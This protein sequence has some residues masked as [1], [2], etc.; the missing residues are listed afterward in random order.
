MNM[1][2]GKTALLVVLLMS[3]GFYAYTR[4]QELT[5][6]PAIN[7]GRD[8]EFTG[9]PPR[10][11]GTPSPEAE[12]R[13][14]EFA[15]TLNLTPQQ[16]EQLQQLRDSN[17][18]R[19]GFRDGMSSFSMI[20]TPQQRTQMAAMRD[21]RRDK[22]ARAVMSASEFQKYQE[23]RAQRRASNPGGPGRRG[24]PGGPG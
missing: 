13:R 3:S 20:L 14:Q 4:Y 18:G 9:R 6:S 15:K 24:G 1:S 12:Q 23:K 21:A 17:G 11:D 2:R 10:P 22:G 7:N 5:P 8:S 19:T 16:E